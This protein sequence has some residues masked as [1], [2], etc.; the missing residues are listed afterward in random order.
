MPQGLKKE[1]E[2]EGFL[3]YGVMVSGSQY[4]LVD[5]SFCQVVS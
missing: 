5:N 4:Y 1:F 3:Y 2:E